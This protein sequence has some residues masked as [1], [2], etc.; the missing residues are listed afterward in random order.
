M[1]AF[2]KRSLIR[3]A[4]KDFDEAAVTAQRGV[5]LI[6]E[7]VLYPIRLASQKLSGTY[8][9]QQQVNEQGK[10]LEKE[11]G[12]P[13]SAWSYKGVGNYYA[14]LG[15]MSLSFK[16]T[17]TRDVIP[18]LEQD[19]KRVEHLIKRKYAEDKKPISHE[20]L[21][22]LKEATLKKVTQIKSKVERFSS[23]RIT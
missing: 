2:G 21:H 19:P 6:T 15:H 16:L 8:P 11:F 12:V 1:L 22:D 18:H 7:G 5:S 4:G 13:K 3:S 20:E 23:N 10:Q 17:L 14:N 9:T